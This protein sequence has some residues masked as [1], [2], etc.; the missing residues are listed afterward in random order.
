[1]STNENQNQ[2]V[3]CAESE[4]TSPWAGDARETWVSL[5]ISAATASLR[6]TAPAAG[7]CGES[8]VGVDPA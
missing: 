1:M 4:T 6:G 8:E 5:A 3:A 2:N 7:D